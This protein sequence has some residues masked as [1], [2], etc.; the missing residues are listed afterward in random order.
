MEMDKL[1]RKRVHEVNAYAKKNKLATQ[2]VSDEAI[3]TFTEAAYQMP[4]DATE[5]DV[6][7]AVGHRYDLLDVEG[8]PKNAWARNIISEGV[9]LYRKTKKDWENEA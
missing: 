4:P 9:K 2:I 1:E 3:I 5:S 8:K 7:Q 6:I